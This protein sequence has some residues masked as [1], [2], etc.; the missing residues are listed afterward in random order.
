[1][2]HG[3]TGIGNEIQKHL[4]NLPGIGQ[5]CQVALRENQLQPDIF[6]DESA[7]HLLHPG[8]DAIQVLGFNIH[9]LFSAESQERPGKIGGT[10]GGSQ[11]L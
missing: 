11:D 2:R 1:M 6:P 5:Q 10:V 7:Q 3:I 4:F 9:G 8:N